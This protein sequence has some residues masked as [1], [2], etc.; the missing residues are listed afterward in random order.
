MVVVAG[1]GDAGAVAGGG[2]EAGVGPGDPGGGGFLFREIGEEVFVGFFGGP[3]G[4]EE[5]GGVP[6]AADDGDFLVAFFHGGADGFSHEG[7]AVGFEG[8]WAR[9]EGGAEGGHGFEDGGEEVFGGGGGAGFDEVV[10]PGFGVGVAG[11]GGEVGEGIDVLSFERR[12]SSFK[13]GW[14][15]DGGFGRGGRSAFDFGV[16]VALRDGRGAVGVF[17]GGFGGFLHGEAV[18]EGE[19]HEAGGDFVFGGVLEGLPFGGEF[20]EGVEGGVVGD[21]GGV[22]EEGDGGFEGVEEV[23]GEGGVGFGGAFDEEEVGLELVEGLL[24]GAGA[25]GAVVADAEDVEGW[26][27]GG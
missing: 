25:A 4:L 24:E 23:R 8:V 12:V 22:D 21:V 11:D 5:D 14:F 16:G 2:G 18:G 7:L 27:M 15:V 6:G 3:G 9:G 10:P 13:W 17:G 20:G 19:V 1:G 26:R